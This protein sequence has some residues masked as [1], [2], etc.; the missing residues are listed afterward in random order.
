MRDPGGRWRHCIIVPPLALFL[1][2]VTPAAARCAP[3]APT[4]TVEA[5]K[6][7]GDSYGPLTNDGAEDRSSGDLRVGYRRGRFVVE[8]RYGRSGYTTENDGPGSR[9]V[10]PT[11]GGGTASVPFFH[12]VESRTE[13]RALVNAGA[14]PFAAGFGVFR[15]DTN[16]GFP[17]LSGIGIG[18]SGTSRPYRRFML[19]SSVFYYPNVLGAYRSLTIRFR[20]LSADAAIAYPIVH[21]SLWVVA[22]YRNEYREPISLPSAFAQVRSSPYLGIRQILGRE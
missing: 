22:G 11:F 5:T 20:V 8:F 4:I 2:I 7:F 17:V 21:S 12:A 10:L 6:S 3:S 13:L 18:V 9:T 19:D 16:Y 14:L 15:A 1:A